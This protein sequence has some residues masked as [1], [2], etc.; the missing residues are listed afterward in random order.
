M[1]R[2]G[3]KTL[4]R[5]ASHRTLGPQPD[6]VEGVRARVDPCA[7]GNNVKRDGVAGRDTIG[8]AEDSE[9]CRVTDKLVTYV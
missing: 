5:K 8:L 6:P 1:P 9:L 2:E 3:M 4:G 7:T